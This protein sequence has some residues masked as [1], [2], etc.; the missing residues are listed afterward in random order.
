MKGFSPLDTANERSF[1]SPFVS[2]L[3]SDLFL[4]FSDRDFWSDLS[5]CLSFLSFI[6]I[7]QFKHL[8]FRLETLFLVNQLKQVFVTVKFDLSSELVNEVVF[9]RRLTFVALF[10]LILFVYWS[11]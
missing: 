8:G 6:G 5:F 4:D 9:F 1:V 10:V 2:F 11:S 3:L 7:R